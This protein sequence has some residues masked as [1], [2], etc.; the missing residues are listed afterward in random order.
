[1]FI[2][3]ATNAATALNL[4]E[5]LCEEFRSMALPHEHSPYGC[6]TVSIGV[7]TMIPEVGGNSK[8][9]IQ[10]ADQAMYRAKELGRN[11]AIPA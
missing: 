2:A 11:R 10:A 5:S 9:L 8:N 6:V 3:P 1:M 7:A 4:A